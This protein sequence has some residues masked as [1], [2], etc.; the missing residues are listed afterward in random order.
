MSSSIV[1][2]LSFSFFNSMLSNSGC[3][4]CQFYL[5]AGLHLKTSVWGSAEGFVYYYFFVPSIFIT[6]KCDQGTQP[7]KLERPPVSLLR[8]TIRQLYGDVQN[9]ILI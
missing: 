7:I 3:A 1:G 2:L 5:L 6:S 4:H 9:C 8:K